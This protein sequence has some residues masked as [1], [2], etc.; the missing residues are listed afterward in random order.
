MN[1]E[2]WYIIS[3]KGSKSV[4]YF[5]WE[6]NYAYSILLEKEIIYGYLKSTEFCRVGINYV[7]KHDYYKEN[8]LFGKFSEEK[9]CVYPGPK[10]LE[11]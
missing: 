9:K 3:Q 8:R 5:G 2:N 11:T 10:Q 6:Q 1:T 4:Y 7:W